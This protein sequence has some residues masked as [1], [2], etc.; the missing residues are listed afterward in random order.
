MDEV[1]VESLLT[2]TGLTVTTGIVVE[3]IKRTLN[4]AKA[5]SERFAPILAIGVGV[6]LAL[7]AAA[8]I[9]SGLTAES[10]LTGILT[11]IF[12]GAAASGIYDVLSSRPASP[13]E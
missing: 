13:P 11:G 12:A 10:V 8:V 2:V 3:V 4:M 9:G 7:V 6:V 5:T 1:P